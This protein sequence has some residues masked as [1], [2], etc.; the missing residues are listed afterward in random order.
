MS[1]N[2]DK[3]EILQRPKLVFQEGDRKSDVRLEGTFEDQFW[4]GGD[5]YI[6]VV[7]KG[8][9]RKMKI[10]HMLR[11]STDGEPQSKKVIK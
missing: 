10:N 8:Q 2:F 9:R 1:I 3:D 4:H 5:C 11:R 6:P 7:Y